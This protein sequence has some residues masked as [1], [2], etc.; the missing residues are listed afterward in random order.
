[1]NAFPVI[2]LEIEGMKH[3]VRQCLSEYAARMDSD[4]QAAINAAIT[5]GNISRI[6]TESA[7]R[8]VKQAI[9]SEIRRFFTYDSEGAQF[10]RHA[11]DRELREHLDR[12]PKWA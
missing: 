9:E 12:M 8:E 2:R 6:V 4:V 11:V 10:I 3:T 1:M 5:P 7:A